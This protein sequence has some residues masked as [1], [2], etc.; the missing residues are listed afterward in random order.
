MC[1]HPF[2]NID[3]EDDELD[4]S[5]VELFN[6][7]Q[8]INFGIAGERLKIEDFEAVVHERLFDLRYRLDL[9]E[10]DKSGVKRLPSFLGYTK[11][12]RLKQ[13]R[14]V[15]MKDGEPDIEFVPFNSP[16]GQDLLERIEERM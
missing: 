11:D 10:E 5:L 4:N 3:I 14:R 15:V 16:K 12:D 6:S 13:F 7:W 2:E 1:H 9:A 8:E